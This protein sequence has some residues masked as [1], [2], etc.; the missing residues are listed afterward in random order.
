MFAPLLGTAPHTA[1][2]STAGVQDQQQ[3]RSSS[4]PA[5][6][7]Q[8]TA[9][10]HSLHAAPK[11]TDAILVDLMKPLAQA[12]FNENLQES[13]QLSQF[14]DLIS[15]QTLAQM[16]DRSSDSWGSSTS[17]RYL[18]NLTESMLK[19]AM[20]KDN[21]AELSQ[22]AINALAVMLQSLN[23]EQA[24][25][26]VSQMLSSTAPSS[27]KAQTTPEA[28]A[29]FQQVSSQVLDMLKQYTQVQPA[30]VV[31]ALSTTHYMFSG[32]QK[33]A[34]ETLLP[35]ALKANSASVIPEIILLVSK[36]STSTH[37]SKSHVEMN[38][39][40]LNMLQSI[41]NQAGIND[42]TL[43]NV[44]NNV[45]QECQARLASYDSSSSQPAAQPQAHS[46]P[47]PPSQPQATSSYG[48]AA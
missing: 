15:S 1:H 10:T 24:Q 36:S 4:T 35:I 23:S 5:P 3:V 16:N 46:Q 19:V 38:L 22:A 28:Q 45:Q 25:V 39:K 7:A 44:I 9:T 41:I 12:V 37:D 32:S 47:Q 26:V 33:Q 42:Q 21:R 13:P 40:K 8:A 43:T 2:L 11:S 6:T 34:L 30:L 29:R 17:A 27:Y 14:S 18:R 31:K 48:L 20:N